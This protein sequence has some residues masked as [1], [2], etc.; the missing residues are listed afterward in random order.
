MVTGA[1]KR[2]KILA[3]EDNPSILDFYREFFSD[4]GFEVKTAEDALSA[5][6]LYQQFKPDIIALDLNIPAGG[7][8]M[9]FDGIRAGHKDPVP[10]I[11]S[12]GKPEM[13]PHNIKSLYK[14]AVIT[15]PTP[16]EALVAEIR[17]LLPHFFD[18]PLNP[19]PP[20][21]PSESMRARAA[22]RRVLVVDDDPAIIALYTEILSK[23]G[24]EVRTAEDTVVAVTVFQEF[25]PDLVVLDVEMPGGGGRKVFERLRI[26]LAS[27]APVLFSTATPA[28]VEDL[29]KN[30][31]VMILK[32][33]VTPGVLTG[34]VRD[35]L[36]LG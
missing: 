5:I 25:K 6:T 27:P 29:A 26:Q 15:K 33:P 1:V 21:P 17:R 9:V 30:L 20:P 22:R 12:T 24:F 3:V 28:S 18:R 11:F 23:A 13:L 7:G 8:M 10:I 19:V 2:I 36:K 4:M 35:L 16:P 34:A 31:N 14:V 32:K